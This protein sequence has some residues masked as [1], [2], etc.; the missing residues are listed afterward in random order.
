M[1]KI[2]LIL[3]DDEQLVLEDLKDIVDWDALGYEIVATARNGKQAMEKYRKLQPELVITDIQMPGMDGIELARKLRESGG[4]PTVILLSAYSDFAYAK[5]ALSHG[6]YDYILKSEINTAMLTDKLIGFR[7]HIEDVQKMNSL[8]REEMIAD[9]MSGAAGTYDEQA[10]EF[11]TKR[12][13]YYV[14]EKDIPCPFVMGSE[15]GDARMPANPEV[16]CRANITGLTVRTVVKLKD[17]RILICIDAPKE[18]SQMVIGSLLGSQARK[19]LTALKGWKNE[20]YTIYVSY[21]ELSLY[22]LSRIYISRSKD[23]AAKYFLGCNRV[24]DLMWEELCCDGQHTTLGL[25]RFQA[26]LKANDS[27]M[28]KQYIE[29]KYDDAISG[30]RYGELVYLSNVFYITLSSLIEQHNEMELLDISSQNNRQYWG[31]AQS[32]K[33]WM[34]DNYAVAMKYIE[35]SDGKKLSPVVSGAVDYIKE[36]YSAYNLKIETIAKSI[37]ISSSRLSVLFKNEMGCTVN[38]YITSFRIW[39]AQLLL[40][41]GKYKVYEVADKVGYGT[42]QYFSQIFYQ[43]VGVSPKEFSRGA[44]DD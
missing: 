12:R 24:Y 9:L 18:H 41:E 11:F 28:V 30:K 8:L 23:L 10:E 43:K 16:F 1:R 25:E 40:R 6:I 38:E 31:Q 42:S 20:S 2:S 17:G 15:D 19:L 3:V 5:R 37:D 39:K 29:Q 33:H 32:I 21:K 36:N 27:E 13:Y 44:S 34:I 7:E 35:R 4:Q 14:V 26:M 22:E